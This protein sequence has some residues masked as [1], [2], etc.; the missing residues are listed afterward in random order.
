MVFLI[1]W[2]DIWWSTVGEA[3]NL[4]VIIILKE[5]WCECDRS[6]HAHKRREHEAFTY[7]DRVK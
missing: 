7:H 6:A 4:N 5:I 1:R 3:V 2:T